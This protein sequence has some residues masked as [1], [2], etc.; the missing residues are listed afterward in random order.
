MQQSK[1]TIKKSREREPV[2]WMF[3][4]NF[5]TIQ[6]QSAKGAVNGVCV[7]VLFPNLPNQPNW[8]TFKTNTTN[9]LSC[10]A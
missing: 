9:S 8:I 3:G 7:C 1:E 5:T 4:V 10:Q 6:G 2:T